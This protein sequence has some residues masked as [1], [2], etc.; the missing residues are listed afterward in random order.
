MTETKRKITGVLIDVWNET[1]E[2][3]SIE[4]SLDAYYAALQCGTIDI[5]SR[6]IGPRGRKYYDIICDDEGL[7]V[8]PTKISAID[9]SCRAAL[10][11]NLFICSHDKDGNEISLTDTEAKRILRNVHHVHTAM[12][13]DGY[14]VLCN[15][16]V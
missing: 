6:R 1:A 11:G 16:R 14:P 12:F 8:A 15:V 3:R 2:V 7:L 5:V 13:P 9:M 10:V 4:A